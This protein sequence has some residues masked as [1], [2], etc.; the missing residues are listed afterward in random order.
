MLVCHDLAIF[1]A[2][3]TS[4]EDVLFKKDREAVCVSGLSP[5]LTY[6]GRRCGAF[7]T[8]AIEIVVLLHDIVGFIKRCC[9]KDESKDR[10]VMIVLCRSP[11][12]DES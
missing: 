10:I 9:L 3:L 12:V 1:H 11:L 4:I 2:P 5:Q 6:V 7:T 8:A